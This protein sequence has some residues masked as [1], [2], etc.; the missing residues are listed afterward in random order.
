MQNLLQDILKTT[1][2]SLECFSSKGFV[3]CDIL[4]VDR[5]GELNNFYAIA[6][7]VI[8]GGSF[9]KMGG[10]N[11]LEP[12]FFNTRL[13]TGEHLFNQVALFELVKPYKIV[14]KEDLLDALLDY[15]NLGVA[16]FL[17]N[18]HDLNELLAFIKH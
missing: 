9:V 6:D 16:C 8:L 7:I 12:A 2:F 18:G 5:L 14:Q 10:H 4:L 3:E 15:K 11:P 17:E 13:I 1:P